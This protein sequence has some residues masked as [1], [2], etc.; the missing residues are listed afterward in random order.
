MKKTATFFG[1]LTRT[2]VGIC[3]FLSASNGMA[4]NIAGRT[5]LDCDRNGIRRAT[6]LGVPNVTVTLR[7]ALGQVVRTATTT[8]TGTYNFDNIADGSYTVAFSFARTATGLA[9][10]PLAQGTDRTIDSDVDATGNSA[11]ISVTT[12][13]NAVVDG[14]IIDSEGP[15]ITFT[16]PILQALLNGDTLTMLCDA[17][18]V[19]DASDAIAVDNSGY[20]S[21]IRFV[22]LG[23]RVGSC[24]REGYRS[25]ISCNWSAFDSC[26]NR[27]QIQIFIKVVDTRAPVFQNV[28][29]NITVT[30][31]T[32]PIAPTTVR[33]L[34]GCDGFIPPV[35]SQAIAADGRSITRT[36]TASDSCGN[37]QTASQ[38]ITISPN[39]GSGGRTNPCN[40]FN[41]DTTF[42]ANVGNDCNAFATFCITGSNNLTNFRNNYSLTDN[43]VRFNAMEEGC[44][45]DTIYTYTYFSIPSMGERPPY[46]LDFW[47]L[48]G[49]NRTLTTFNSIPQLVDSMNRWDPIGNWRIDT[50][51][52]SIIGGNSRNRY[53]DMRITRIANGAFGLLE[54]NTGLVSNGI[55][56]RLAVGNHTIVIR[57]NTS[58]C[59]DTL[60][61]SVLCNGQ[62]RRPI[63]RDDSYSTT[64]NTSLTFDPVLN[65]SIFGTL[66]GGVQ[67]VSNPRHGNIG[68]GTGSNVIYQPTTG[69][70]G[71]D[72]FEYRICNQFFLC[73]TGMVVFNVTCDTT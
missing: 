10:S 67:I 45:F 48:N 15:K 28:P 69:Y 54:L 14:G 29:S 41:V 37:R 33:A 9:F 46:R 20:S 49:V 47:S 62:N 57:N 1:R 19:F 2:L 39:G 22:D 43:G 60:Y 50:T 59:T 17:M 34:D 31:A 24:A 36:W 18:R 42:V 64:R 3:L 70:C 23:I 5:F 35:F 44:S 61:A 32:V 11:P 51:T 68:F 52:F 12:S 56:L 53:G 30:A 7:T 55:G 8:N 6:D 66:T 27:S 25:L 71:R 38:I 16:T 13:S 73:D 26:G 21:P 63:A 72:T 4:G 65:D 58:G 40:L